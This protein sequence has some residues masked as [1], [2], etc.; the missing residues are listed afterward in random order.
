[1][2]AGN[3]KN[4]FLSIISFSSGFSVKKLKRGAQMFDIKFAMVSKL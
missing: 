2:D 3:K 4:I 1:M